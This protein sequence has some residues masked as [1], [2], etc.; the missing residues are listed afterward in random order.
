MAIAAVGMAISGIGSFGRG[1]INIL[2][3]PIRAI[4]M[5]IKNVAGRP[6]IRP[7]VARGS[8]YAIGA[9]A[10]SN[11][12]YHVSTTA[13]LCAQ[14]ARLLLGSQS[15]HF[16]LKQASPHLIRCLERLAIKEGGRLF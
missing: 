4:I 6:V 9:A 15:R 16:F 2:N 3:A 11:F 1:F 12:S 13:R 5:P 8:F 10:N 7:G 14:A